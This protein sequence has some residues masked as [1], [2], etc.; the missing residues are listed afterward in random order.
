MYPITGDRYQCKDCVEAIGFDL[1]GDCYNTRSKLPGRFNQQHTPEHR[2]ELVKTSN[3]C[4]M[5]MRFV[6]G[7]VEDVSAIEIADDV[8][9]VESPITLPSDAEE[10]TDDDHMIDQNNTEPTN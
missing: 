5:M 3:F 7:R 6:T 4:D 2:L 9:E 1:C 8:L 10:N